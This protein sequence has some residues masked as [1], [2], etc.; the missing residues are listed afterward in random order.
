MPAV[1]RIDR[2]G[3]SPNLSREAKQLLRR[4]GKAWLQELAR[5]ADMGDAASIAA[6]A[7]IA[8]QEPPGRSRPR[9][10]NSRRGDGE[11][12]AP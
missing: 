10:P 1:A 7:E 12:P 5:L 11:A 9:L 3:P 4:R 8:R 2:G 6:I